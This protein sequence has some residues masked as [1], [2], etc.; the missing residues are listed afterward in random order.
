MARHAGGHGVVTALW[1]RAVARSPV[2][3]WLAERQGGDNYDSGGRKECAGQGGVGRRSL[4]Q[5]DTV[6][7][8]GG[9]FSGGAPVYL[10]SQCRVLHHQD[11]KGVVRRIEKRR[12]TRSG[13]RSPV[14]Q[15][16][17]WWWLHFRWLLRRSGGGTRTGG[18]GGRG[19][20]SRRARKGKRW[21]KEGSGGDGG[22]AL[23]K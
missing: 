23:L 17:Q 6:Q 21:E 10:V 16:L 1:A 2:T 3:T 19:G 4:E 9:G 20:C 13:W 11:G 15:R 22:N 7:R 8:R 14:R 12:E 5:H 18:K